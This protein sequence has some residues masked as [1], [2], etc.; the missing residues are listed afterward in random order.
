[1][2]VQSSRRNQTPQLRKQGCEKRVGVGMAEEL[3]LLAE[4]QVLS[5][6]I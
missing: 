6:L 2:S 1:M 4:P 3:K 5:H